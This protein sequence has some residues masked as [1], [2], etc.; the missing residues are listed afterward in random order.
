[1]S[2]NSSSGSLLDYSIAGSELR[3]PARAVATGL[4]VLLTAASAQV[5][6][7]IP[8]TPIPFVLTPLAVLLCGAALGSRLGAITQATYLLIGAAGLPVFAPN[9]ALP[10][11]VLRLFGPTGGYLW[12][13]P[14]AAFVAGW[15][16]ER[17]WDR[18]YLTSVAA[19]IVGLAIIYLGGLAWFTLSVTHSMTSSIAAGA[20]PWLVAADILK[21]IAAATILPQAWRLLGRRQ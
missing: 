20:F 6:F 17:G 4:A 5:T 16:A 18:R 11:G 12:A 13:Y 9:P 15:L 7:P 14:L 3:V 8:H 21:V 2:A 10:P 19:M 1:M